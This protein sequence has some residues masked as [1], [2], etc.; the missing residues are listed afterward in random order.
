MNIWV[1]GYNSLFHE[2]YSLYERATQTSYWN[3]KTQSKKRTTS[4]SNDICAYITSMYTKVLVRHI[5][6]LY[7]CSILYLLEFWFAHLFW[8]FTFHP[9]S[10]LLNKIKVSV[11]SEYFIG[12]YKIANYIKMWDDILYYILH[13]AVCRDRTHHWL[14]K[15]LYSCKSNYHTIMTTNH[16]KF[17]CI[18]A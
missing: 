7:L 16:I 1:E 11:R 8:Q 17:T 2:S 6:K 14:H 12:I 5:Q 3:S 4:M 13:L 15:Q 10:H 18:I 9:L